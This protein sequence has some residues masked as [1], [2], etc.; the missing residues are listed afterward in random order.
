M[1]F[2]KRRSRIP[3]CDSTFLIRCGC[4]A[5]AR[6]NKGCEFKDGCDLGD[7]CVLSSLNISI[8]EN[9]PKIDWLAMLA[10]VC[11]G[12]SPADRIFNYLKPPLRCIL[13]SNP[14]LLLAP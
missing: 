10:R 7:D 6:S 3:T 8:R 4:C 11:G 1:E 9:S 12:R 13:R 5:G 14:K 2:G